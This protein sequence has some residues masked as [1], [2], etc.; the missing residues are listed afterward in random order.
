MVLVAV[1][2][3]AAGVAAGVAKVV[4][5]RGV[6]GEVDMMIRLTQREELDFEKVIQGA[7]KAS[8]GAWVRILVA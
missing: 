8:T 4:L 5:L 1:T 7:Q 3:A 2:R 6:V